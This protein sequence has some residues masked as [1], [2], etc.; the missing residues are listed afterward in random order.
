MAPVGPL[1]ALALL[2]EGFQT[3]A[4]GTGCDQLAT[5]DRLATAPASVGESRGVVRI[6]GTA[7]AAGVSELAPV[8]GLGQ[9][10]FAGLAAGACGALAGGLSCPHLAMVWAVPVGAADQRGT[11]GSWASARCAWHQWTRCRGAGVKGLTVG[12]SRAA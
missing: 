10:V 5:V 9:A 2:I 12:L 3:V 1:T 6:G 4:V 11:V 8:L 7:G